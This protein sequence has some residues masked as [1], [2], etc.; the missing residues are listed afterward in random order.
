[1]IFGLGPA[2]FEEL[3]YDSGQV[4]NPNLSDYMI[5]SILDIPERLTSSAVESDDENADVHGVGEMT[6]PPLAPAIANAV[7]RATG[8]RIR[9]LPMTPER[10]L[11]AI[12]DSRAEGTR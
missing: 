2:L 1:M 4:V 11:R 5:P 7:F 9:D 12:D 10:V 8:A 3:V 6:V